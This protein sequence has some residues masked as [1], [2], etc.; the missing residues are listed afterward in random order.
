MFY[1]P[2][3]VKCADGST[4]QT[5]YI[6]GLE[7]SS[8]TNIV[9][10]QSACMPRSWYNWG[11]RDSL[12]KL[13]LKQYMETDLIFRPKNRGSFDPAACESSLQYHIYFVSNEHMFIHNITLGRNYIF[14][15]RLQTEVLFEFK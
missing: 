15:D 1:N 7:V 9:V 6:K 12:D 3:P 4:L 11:A 13:P 8:N 5:K 10:K 14:A 2:A